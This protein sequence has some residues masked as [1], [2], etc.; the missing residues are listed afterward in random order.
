MI[1]PTLL[2][3]LPAYLR[4]EQIEM[5]PA[6]LILSLRVE[7]TDAACP[8]C[9][10]RSHRIHSY[11]TRTLADLPCAAKALQLLVLVRRFFCENDACDRKIFAEWLTELT[12]V[13]ARRTTRCI[14]RLAELGFVLGGKAAVE[15]SAHLGLESSRMTILSIL[16]KEPVPVPPAPS[17][18]SV[19]EFAPPRNKRYGTILMNLEDATPVD[20][21]PDRQAATLEPWLK[22]HPGV[23]LLSRDRAG[24]FSRGAKEGAPEALQTADRFHVLRNL[25]ETV[26]RVLQRHRKAL[27]Q[28]Y[29]VTTPASPPSVLRAS[30]Q[31]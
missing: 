11:Y 16:R 27:K 2:L 15:L 17:M 20:F 5:T 24:E 18:L 13:Y 21:L 22:H 9:Q 25:T 1:Q 29:L 6:T 30:S 3:A 7:T 14:K 10:Q 12:N 26:E 23:Q 8:L 31:T 4:L 28:I 19:G